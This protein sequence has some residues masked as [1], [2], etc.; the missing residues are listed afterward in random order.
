MEEKRLIPAN[1]FC[2][3]HQLEINFIYLLREYGLVEIVSE[4]GSDF[5]VRDKLEELER[6]IRL[7][8]ELQLNMEGIDVVLHLLE[9]LQASQKEV[10]DLKNQ[11]RLY[12]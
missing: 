6:I 7:H 2:T 11:L 8:Y 9:Q 3:Q 12:S 1:E 4:E 5:L 10:N